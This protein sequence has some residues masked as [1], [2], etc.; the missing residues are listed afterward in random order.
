[1]AAPFPLAPVDSEDLDALEALE[2]EYAEARSF[3]AVL[4]P[5][6]LAF[7]ALILIGVV[8][9]HLP[10]TIAG[11][12]GT[13]AAGGVV[14]AVR[15]EWHARRRWTA[16]TRSLAEAMGI[17]PRNGSLPT[18]RLLRTA[19]GQGPVRASFEAGPPARGDAPADRGR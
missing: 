1:M 2:L 5:R 8:A 6:V 16:A 12:A 19:G 7:I 18:V 4:V 11:T 10:W 13:L 14:L 3:R 17:R 15:M 9:V